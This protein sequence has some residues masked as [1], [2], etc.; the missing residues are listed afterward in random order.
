MLRGRHFPRERFATATI[1]SNGRARSFMSGRIARRARS[2]IPSSFTVSVRKAKTSAL[3]RKWPY[4]TLDS[5]Q[6]QMYIPSH[7]REENTDRLHE[8][9]R[10]Y[11]FALIIS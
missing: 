7:F 9:I 6:N 11:A 8:V 3:Q 2:G 10:S 4:S 1:D 5:E